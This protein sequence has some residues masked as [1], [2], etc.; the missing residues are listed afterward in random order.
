MRL[1]WSSVEISEML[2]S[3]SIIIFSVKKN[4]PRG[5]SVDN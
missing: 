2:E 1:R 4:K 3:S 5:R